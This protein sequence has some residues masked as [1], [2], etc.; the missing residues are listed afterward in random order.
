MRSRSPCTNVSR[1]P[2]A[3]PGGARY[4]AP[5]TRGGGPRRIGARALVVV[6]LGQPVA[7]PLTMSTLS[8]ISK[9]GRP[10]AEL[11]RASREHDREREEWRHRMTELK[12][13]RAL[14]KG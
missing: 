1:P 8:R 3:R 13:K 7:Q 6:G 14:V 5:W 4:S 10:S 12:G 9:L 2:D 11:L